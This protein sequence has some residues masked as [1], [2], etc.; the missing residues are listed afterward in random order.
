MGDRVCWPRVD[1]MAESSMILGGES[2]KCK[3]IIY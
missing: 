3:Q 2:V 1:L